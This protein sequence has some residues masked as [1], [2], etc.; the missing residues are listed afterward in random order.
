MKFTVSPSAGK[1][2]KEEMVNYVYGIYEPFTQEEIAA[3][4]Q[5][6]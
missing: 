6:C 2:S 4:M 3:K 1:L 5:K